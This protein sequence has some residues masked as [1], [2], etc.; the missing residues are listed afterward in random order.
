M[1]ALLLNVFCAHLTIL[2]A[3]PQLFIDL[4]IL[5]IVACIEFHVK[6]PECGL[7]AAERVELEQGIVGVKTISIDRLLL[8]FCIMSVNGKKTVR[9]VACAPV[10]S[11]S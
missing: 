7:Q 2:V 4:L 6:R 3:L 11:D 1:K 9:S 8:G 5:F 10:G